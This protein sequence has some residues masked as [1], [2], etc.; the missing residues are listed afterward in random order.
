MFRSVKGVNGVTQKTNKRTVN[1]FNK[2]AK[3]KDNKSGTSKFVKVFIILM[4]IAML[5]PLLGTLLF[6]IF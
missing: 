1:D 6:Q 3:R 4:S 5:V 2:K